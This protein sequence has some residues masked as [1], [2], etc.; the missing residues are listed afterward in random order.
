MILR[1]VT[2]LFTR[3]A[4]T[5][6]VIFI[7]AGFGLAFYFASQVAPMLASVRYGPS[8]ELSERLSE[9]TTEYDQA[10]AIVLGLRGKTEFPD[11]YAAANIEPQFRATYE[12]AGDFAELHKSLAVVET[13]RAAMKGYLTDTADSLIGDIQQ[14]L[15]AHAGAL[16]AEAAPTT[17]PTPLPSI[18]AATPLPTPSA[19][20]IFLSTIS[21][22]SRKETL[23]RVKDYLGTLDES[24]ENPENKKKLE[25][26]ISEIALLETLIPQPVAPAPAAPTPT[27]IPLSETP[28]PPEPLPAEK[29][30]ARL[31][32]LRDDLRNTLILAWT[33]DQSYNNAVAAADNEERNFG[34]SQFITRRISSEL[35]LRMAEAITAGLALGL[36]FF[37]IGDWTK[38]SGTEVVEYWSELLENINVSPKEVYD[39]VEAAVKAREV[40][41][42]ETSR[43]FWH[44]GGAISAKREYL[45]FARERLVFEICAAPFG[46][47]SFLSFRISVVPLV[48]DPLGIFLV[49]VALAIL[50]AFFVALFG[51]LWGAIILILGL[52]L[53]IFALRA[54]IARGLADLDR[55]F[56]KMPLF[57]SLYE[58]LLRPITY[59]RIDTMDMYSKAV[60]KSVSE[61]FNSMF[62]EKG[63][64]LMPS[65]I[66]KPVLDRLYKR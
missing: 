56:M 24:A 23:D 59:Y 54:V 64:T 20:T 55:A 2:S 65:S 22:E 48:I 9:L 25:A 41:G 11:P 17:T 3:F 52:S 13:G 32:K 10:K 63:M 36:L 39:Q 27:P 18:P 28:A 50:L 45:R 7:L 37:L 58:I 43:E 47:D 57:G 31:F 14:Q 40:P 30:A 16:R 15:L 35:Y 33:L 12:S 44:E 4:K 5:F 53:L 29:V 61:S 21:P 19:P 1:F 6:G 38:K 34:Y 51:M 46:T 26:S 62:G 49:F 42:L 8:T 60:Q 66:A